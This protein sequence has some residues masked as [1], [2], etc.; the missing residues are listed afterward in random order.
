MDALLPPRRRTGLAARRADFAW[1]VL[2]FV[3]VS[4]ISDALIDW[5]KPEWLDEE[6]GLRRDLLR[7]QLTADPSRPILLGLGSSRIGVGFRPEVLPEISTPDGRPVLFFNGS[8]LAGG[9]IMSQLMLHRFVRDGLRPR[10][11]LL[12]AAPLLLDHDYCS[13]PTTHATSFDLRYTLPYVPLGKAALVYFRSRL[14]PFYKHR[15]YVLETYAPA[16]ACEREADDSLLMGPLGGCLSGW[17]PLA[18]SPEKSEQ[19]TARVL[20]DDGPFYG[21]F[22]ADPKCDR[23]LRDLISWSLKEGIGVTVLLTPE[24]SRLRALYTAEAQ[25][26]IARYCE[27]L[28]SR[29]GITVIDART[30]LEDDGFFDGHHLLRAGSI[31]LTHRLEAR[32]LRPL[33]EGRLVAH[34]G[35]N[36]HVGV[37]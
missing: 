10:W 14:N 35:G 7:A 36:G 12:E 20:R 18:M 26:A 16:L 37:Q 8:H 15:Q 32:V 21:R 25:Q 17:C 33:V 2:L 23:A 5:G 31:R 29:F 28:E 22:K 27:D 30:W 19:M 4:L 9:P 11:I 1:F 24:S 6:Y 3:V 13:V 34:V